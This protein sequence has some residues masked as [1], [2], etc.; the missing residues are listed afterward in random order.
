MNADRERER[1]QEREL[2]QNRERNKTNDNEEWHRY[3]RSASEERHSQS[4]EYSHPI[5]FSPQNSRHFGY[6]STMMTY[7]ER[8][9]NNRDHSIHFYSD[10]SVPISNDPRRRLSSYSQPPFASFPPS[11]QFVSHIDSREQ[12][13]SSSTRG[14]HENSNFSF[15]NDSVPHYHRNHS[16][17]YFSFNYPNNQ[18][19]FYS[20]LNNSQSVNQQPPKK[21]KEHLDI[22]NHKTQSEEGIQQNQIQTSSNRETN[23]L[24]N[25]KEITNSNCFGQDKRNHFKENPPSDIIDLTFTSNQ[26]THF[27]IDKIL[28]KIPISPTL[29]GCNLFE[30]IV[31][32]RH[33]NFEDYFNVNRDKDVCQPLSSNWTVKNPNITSHS[34]VSTQESVIFESQHKGASKSFE[35]SE[36]N[37]TNDVSMEVNLYDD[38]GLN[39][40]KETN[41]NEFTF[42]QGTQQYKNILIPEFTFEVF[43]ILRHFDQTKI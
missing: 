13:N 23:D 12:F 1:E 6:P 34:V 17:E 24:I 16:P 28:S 42:E 33:Q 32:F 21:Q 20:K 41:L 25:F 7:N 11:S 43:S 10:F 35:S 30:V 22:Q 39:S 8:N 14:Y 27:S 37:A 18:S 3:Y 29:A 4:P 40:T 15:S 2:Q 19:K 5:S 38:L 9:K 26:S 31:N 36:D